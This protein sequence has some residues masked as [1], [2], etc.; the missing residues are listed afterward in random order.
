[1]ILNSQETLEEHKDRIRKVSNAS[2][3]V[4]CRRDTQGT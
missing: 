1:M 4:E 3:N 2:E